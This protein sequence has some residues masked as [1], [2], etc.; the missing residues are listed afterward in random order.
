[1]KHIF[2]LTLCLAVLGAATPSTAHTLAT[3]SPRLQRTANGDT[4]ALNPQPIPPGHTLPTTDKL[5]MRALNPQPIPPG[6]TPLG[7]GP[8]N[9]QLKAPTSKASPTV[10]WDVRV[11][12]KS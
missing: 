2:T 7:G 3:D 5:N 8:M 11:N 1:M 10:K 6:H 9:T 4:H 12:N